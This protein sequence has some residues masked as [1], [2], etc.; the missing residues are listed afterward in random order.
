MILS[1]KPIKFHKTVSAHLLDEESTD[2]LIKQLETTHKINT[3]IGFKTP[4]FKYFKNIRTEDFDNLRKYQ[5]MVTANWGLNPLWCLWLTKING[6]HYNLYIN[7]V[8]RQIIWSRHRFAPALY[9]GTLFEGEM[10][11]DKFVIWDILV[12]RNNKLEHNHN[13]R[14]DI[15]RGILLHQ[16][17]PDPVVENVDIINREYVTYAN[18]RSY[19]NKITDNPPFPG[20]T[21]RGLVFVPMGR[22]LKHYNLIFSNRTS[23]ERFKGTSDILE[24]PIDYYPS[25]V[26]WAPQVFPDPNDPTTMERDFWLCPVEGYEDNYWQHIPDPM[27][28]D[29]EVLRIGLVITPTKEESLYVRKIFDKE[30]ITH[31]KSNIRGLLRFRCRYV[32]HFQKWS[33]YLFLT[34]E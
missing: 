13:R 11:G 23:I 20:K 26:R 31:I 1:W 25:E 10:I 21:P 8:T 4:G 7:L 28:P 5:H 19:L 33:P 14:Q 27:A 29:T 3:E 17:T 6:V 24:H 16:Y 30:A 2:K 18:I 15:I 12:H 34:H 9:K 22:T 32:P